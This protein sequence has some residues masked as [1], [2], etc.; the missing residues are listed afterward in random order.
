[1]FELKKV[2][3]ERDDKLFLVIEEIRETKFRNLDDWK[4]WKE[5]VQADNVF[6]NGEFLVFVKEVPEAEYE[7]ITDDQQV[8]EE[9]NNTS[10]DTEK[11]D[12][13]DKKIS[14]RRTPRRK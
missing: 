9:T 3:I 12:D 5:Y 2:F 13:T 7:M 1:V 10:T 6:R 4:I 11:I 8:P 14:R